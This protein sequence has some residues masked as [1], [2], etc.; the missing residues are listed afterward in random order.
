M[1][2]LSGPNRTALVEDAPQEW[3]VL[4]AVQIWEGSVVGSYP[5]GGNAGYLDRIEADS[6]L[7]CRG[8]ARYNVLGTSDGKACTFV[9]EKIIP[10]QFSGGLDTTKIGSLV[11]AVDT[12]TGTLSSGTPPVGIL[13]GVK[14][15]TVGLVGGG[16]TFIARAAAATAATLTSANPF[17]VDE[18]LAP[19]ATSTTALKTATA[20]VNGSQTISTFV[21]GGVT[22]LVAVP[23]NIT[24]TGGGTTGQCPTSANITGTDYDGNALLET[25]ALTAGSG[26]GVKAFKT[27]TSVVYPDGTGTAGT[28]AIGI[29]SVFGLSKTIKS[30]AHRL[31]VIQEVYAASTT[32]SVV[33]N[34]T[35]TDSS[36]SPPH[37]S[38]QGNSAPDGTKSYA[39]TYEHS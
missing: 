16:P 7:I 31:A 13:Y 37:G 23:R 8:V 22:A 2:T 15:A 21:A 11:Y 25:V 29:G 3:A 6:S 24:F 19:A 20:T 9:D 26:T 28:V 38:Y 27:L 18:W 35:Y 10:M 33:T 17:Q 39:L 1:T 34:G 36:T 5:S 14:S 32:G 4:N 12:Q 30:R